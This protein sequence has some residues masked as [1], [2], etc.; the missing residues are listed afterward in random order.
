MVAILCEGTKSLILI[1]FFKLGIMRLCS[2]N[3]WQIIGAS[4]SRMLY[5][6]LTRSTASIDHLRIVIIPLSVDLMR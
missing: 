6:K 3:K 4:I 1:T 2:W 5:T